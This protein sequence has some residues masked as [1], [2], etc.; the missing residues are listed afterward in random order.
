MIERRTDGVKYHSRLCPRSFQHN[1]K[2]VSV[3]VCV[4]VMPLLMFGGGG[5]VGITCRKRH[6]N[7][8]SSHPVQDRPG[9]FHRSW[10]RIVSLILMPLTV[11]KR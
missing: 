6:T 1:T 9:H 11:H 8:T 10:P 3:G 7:V 4:C 2:M 5:Q